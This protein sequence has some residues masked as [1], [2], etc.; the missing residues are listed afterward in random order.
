LPIMVKPWG[1]GKRV[2]ERGEGEETEEEGGEKG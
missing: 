2:E 1:K